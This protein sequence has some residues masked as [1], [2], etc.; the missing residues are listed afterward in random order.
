MFPAPLDHRL[1]NM[2]EIEFAGLEP[3]EGCV[4]LGQDVSVTFAGWTG[5][6]QAIVQ[7]TGLERS[8]GATSAGGGELG[9]GGHVELAE[10]A[11]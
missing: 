1:P 3:P 8:L 5:L 4:R 11:P 6:I 7:L 2:I 10:D 9:S